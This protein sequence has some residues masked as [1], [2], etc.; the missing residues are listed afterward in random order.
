M[1]TRQMALDAMLSAMCAVLGYLAID[2]G[3]LK[4]TFESLPVLLGALLFGPLDGAVIGGVGTLIY[5]LLR[6]GVSVTTPLWILPYV[7][8]GW[9]CGYVARKKAFS[10]SRRETMI[11]VVA[12]ELLITLINTGVLYLDSVI[13]H[14]YFPGFI[15]G[16]L[17][18]RLVICVG[19]ALVFGA[20]LPEL[21]KAT[22]KAAKINHSE[23]E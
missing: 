15:T 19:K 5:Q 11:L 4:I 14:Y 10:L 12:C 16:S 8:A 9:L 1:K 17:A 23:A 22:A 21:V 6:Y 13:F 18:L 7:L 20:V 2:L 3:N